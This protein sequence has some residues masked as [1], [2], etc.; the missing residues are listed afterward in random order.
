MPLAS[1]PLAPSWRWGIRPDRGPPDGAGRVSRRLERAEPLELIGDRSSD[2]VTAEPCDSDIAALENLVE[3]AP[4][5]FAGLVSWASYLDE[6]GR[7]GDTWVTDEASPTLIATPVE[8]L[9]NLGA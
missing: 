6:I 1:P 5:T 7:G 4:T 3:T 9:G 2:W 8:A